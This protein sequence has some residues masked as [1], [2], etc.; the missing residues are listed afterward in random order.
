MTPIQH[1]EQAIRANDSL[2]IEK[3]IGQVPAER[4]RDQSIVALTLNHG[5]LDTLKLLDKYD[6]LNPHNLSMV[7]QNVARLKDHEIVQ[8]M[9]PFF[10][11]K[12]C[13]AIVNFCIY[14]SGYICLREIAQTYK[15]KE[16]LYLHCVT[17]KAG[18]Y[19]MNDPQDL[20]PLMH[21]FDNLGVTT[22]SAATLDIV[23]NN[24]PAQKV[25]IE[26]GHVEKQE[27][28]FFMMLTEN[29]HTKSFVHSKKGMRLDSPENFELFQQSLLHLITFNIPQQYLERFNK[30]LNTNTEPEFSEKLIDLYATHMNEEFKAHVFRHIN[31]Q[32]E[33]E[34]LRNTFFRISLA[35][36][37][38]KSL[39]TQTTTVKK[40]KV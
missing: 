32:K 5:N 39:P 34:E 33:R 7:L 14:H 40:F 21:I 30:M 3:Y 27:L 31:H 24:L 26:H 16:E 12:Q 25:L 4:K 19:A 35:M 2:L 23:K 1:F 8:F 28:N 15:N 22:L 37:L 20:I 11:K 18:D 6:F 36:E 10:D 9:L 38:E 17:T 13:K 29:Y